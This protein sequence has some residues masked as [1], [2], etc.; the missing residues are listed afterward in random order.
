M[1]ADLEAELAHHREL[2]QEHG[3]PV[4]LGNTTVVKESVLELWRFAAV[5]NAWRDLQFAVRGLR[6]NPVFSITAIASLA[7]GIAMSTAMFSLFNAVAFRPLP[8]ASPERIVWFTQVLKAN[9]TDEIT[10]TPAFLEW[11]DSN[12]TFQSMAAYNFYTRSLTGIAEPIEIETVKASSTLLPILGISPMLGRNFQRSEDFLGHDRVVMLSYGLWRDRF[13]S[14]KN[15]LG[16]PILLDGDQYTV[17]GILP[18]GFLFPDSQQVD[19][20]TPLG[21]NEAV[22][23][24]GQGGILTLIHNVIGRLKPGVTDAQA[25]QDLSVVQAH[26]PVPAFHPTI[27]IKLLSLRDLFVRQHKIHRIVASLGIALVSIDRKR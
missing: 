21:K 5:E 16:R 26:L 23:R 20:I 7:L 14:D 3:N 18:E 1:S 12:R 24:S 4:N 22:E 2:A 25:R 8:Y 19:A 9:S 6:R 10:L 11:R 27:T 15:I 17:I 13:S